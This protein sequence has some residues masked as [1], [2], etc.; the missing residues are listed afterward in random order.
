MNDVELVKEKIDVVDLIGEYVALK[1]AGVNHKG[2]CPF[3]H[4][5]S[6]S[7]MANRERG[8][9]HCF[10]C[11][12]GGDIFSFVEEI[13]GLDF[14]EALKFLANRAG[15]QL[16]NTRSEVNT[17]Q[18]NRL[19]DIVDI[20]AR[21]FHHILLNVPA[22][23][24]A[25][26]Y[27]NLRGLSSGAIDAWSLGYAP[28]QWD[29]LT[30]YLLKKGYA[31][32]DLVAAGLS[33]KR[34]GKN[35]FY[36]RFRGRIM[37]PIWDVHGTIVGFTGRVLVETEHSGGKYVNT[38]QTSLYDKSRVVFALNKAKQEI[39]A[40]NLTVM[41]EGQMDVIACHEAGMRNVVATSGTALTLEQVKLLKRYSNNIAIA[42]DADA[43]GIAAAKR[44]IDVALAEGMNIRV[45][46]IPEGAGKDPDECLKKNPAVWFSAVEQ[47]EEI[48]SWY[49]NRA[50]S[51]KNIHDPKDKQTIANELL[52]DIARIPFAVEADHWL[53]ELGGRLSVDV[54]VLREDM[55]RLRHEEKTPRATASSSKALSSA[56]PEGRLSRVLTRL[57]ALLCHTPQFFFSP[58]LDLVMP[59]LIGSPY[60]ALYESLRMRYTS[61]SVFSPQELRAAIPPDNQA[62]VDTLLLQGDLLYADLPMDQREKELQLLTVEAIR[63]WEKEER[64]RLKLA[65]EAAEKTN[66]AE[67]LRAL[68]QQF[69]TLRHV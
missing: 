48:M 12:K 15:V 39:R 4:E 52:T 45:I 14:I 38:P 25:R 62:L 19:K 1:P 42:F 27:L 16:T 59:T 28:E 63:E 40:K 55:R 3:H 23:E 44:G 60:R 24:G 56:P 66:D 29:L 43:A 64:D 46:R 13:E 41:V 33:I 54:S 34:E 20:A 31:V 50:F 9:W 35:S 21:F 68:F 17:S 53:R 51:K 18:K 32:D 7:F 26:N 8:S 36:D 58:R 67:S 30:Q 2:L 49:F 37:F 47:A 65:I 69:E 57:F 11:A 10:G 61:G 22:A 6:P 5:K